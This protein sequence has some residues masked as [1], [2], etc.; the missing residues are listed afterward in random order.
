M[1]NACDNIYIYSALSSHLSRPSLRTGR[2]WMLDH[3]TPTPAWDGWALYSHTS[4]WN[5]L[6]FHSGGF[7]SITSCIIQVKLCTV[8]ISLRYATNLLILPH[9]PPITF[10]SLGKDNSTS[11]SSLSKRRLIQTVFPNHLPMCTVGTLS[12]LTDSN[13][14]FTFT[15]G[16][17]DILN[18]QVY[19]SVTTTLYIASLPVSV[20]SP[21]SSHFYMPF[22]SSVQLR[23]GTRE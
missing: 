14:C 13:A 19:P 11:A 1:N 12:L 15:G 10:W 21:D 18:S 8:W 6:P 17:W 16:L 2:S 23:R 3:W 20:I 5:S 9:W 22:S 7:C 4:A